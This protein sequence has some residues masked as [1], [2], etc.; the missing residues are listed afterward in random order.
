M[1]VI[2]AVR[3]VKWDQYAHCAPGG[4]SPPRGLSD[5]PGDLVRTGAPAQATVGRDPDA[6]IAM[7]SGLV[8][9]SLIVRGDPRRDEP[10]LLHLVRHGR[11]R[12]NSEHRVQGWADSE[13][14]A[15][16]LAGVRATADR[17]RELDLAAA[18]ASPSGRTVTTAREILRHHPRLELVTDPRLRELHFGRFEERPETS[19]AEAGDPV[20]VFRGIFEGTFEG[21][22]GGEPGSVFV[23]RVARGFRA[24]EQAHAHGG[25]VLVVSHGVTLMTYLRLIG[26]RVLHQLPN[27][28]VT[29]VRMDA[30]GHREVLQLGVS[31]P[32]AAIE[33]P[34]LPQVAASIGLEEAATWHADDGIEEAAP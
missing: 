33:E 1:V 13:L 4:A 22:P 23:S 29:V 5:H 20:T 28:S 34:E 9:G 18:Y 31:P 8:A 19:L 16:G 3:F 27:G 21:F 14:T 2:E 7:R 32:G 30:D 26:A 24:I 11:T 6:S 10:L 17:L 25:A 12:L 15:D